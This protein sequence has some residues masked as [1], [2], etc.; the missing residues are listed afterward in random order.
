MI[1]LLRVVSVLTVTLVL[2]IRKAISLII[3]IIGIV[4]VG[5]TIDG[6]VSLASANICSLLGLDESIFKKIVWTTLGCVVRSLGV[7]SRE[8]L[9][10]GGLEGSSWICG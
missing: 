2:V 7:P 3:S 10:L 8:S 4:H 6:P 1:D 9:S 5:R